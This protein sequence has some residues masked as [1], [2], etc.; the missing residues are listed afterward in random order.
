ME[1]VNRP[2]PPSPP[3]HTP[4]PL[5]NQPIHPSPLL[6]GPLPTPSTPLAKPGAPLSDQPPRVSKNPSLSAFPYVLS[7]F[8]PP[9]ANMISS[10]DHLH[11]L[12]HV[13][14]GDNLWLGVVPDIDRDR[15]DIRPIYIWSDISGHMLLFI[16]RT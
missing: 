2:P 7:P 11:Y 12:A 8:P 10:C 6:P 14:V 15:L 16:W 5:L 4:L 13:K 9:P 3:P 1:A